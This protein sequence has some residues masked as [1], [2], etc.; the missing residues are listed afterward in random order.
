MK[1]I[2]GFSGGIDSQACAGWVLERCPKEDVILM[3]STA[4]QNEHPLTTEHVEWYSKNVH[5][6]VVVDALVKDI[7]RT[8]G[9]AETKGYDGN[10][11]LTFGR[12]IEIKKMPPNHQ[13]QYC[14]TILKLYPQKRWLDEHYPPPAEYVKYSGVRRDESR[15]RAATKDEEWDDFFDCLLVHPIAAWTKEQCFDFCRGRGEKINPLYTLGFSRVGCAPCVNANREDIR[16]WARRFPEMIDKVRR[17]ERES[18]CTFFRP[19]TTS[20]KV[21]TIDEVVEWAMKDRG[22]KGWSLEVLYKPEACS[23]KYG[24]CE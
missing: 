18:G 13:S 21:N 15:R 20:G 1:H 22:A 4:G 19:V 3:N 23:S 24:L 6:V 17:W 11:V 14:T 2:V 12:L 10:E 5:P 8:E 9:W 7:W 16:N